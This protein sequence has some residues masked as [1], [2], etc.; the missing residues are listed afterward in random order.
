MNACSP[1]LRL[2]ELTTPFPWTFLRPVSMTDHLEESIMTG[3]RE[4]Y[5]S[6]GNKA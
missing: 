1:S 2:T 4:I 6:G 3:T 5:G